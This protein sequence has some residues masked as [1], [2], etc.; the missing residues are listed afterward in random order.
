MD[1]VDESGNYAACRYCGEVWPNEMLRDDKRTPQH[2]FA[3]FRA[4]CAGSGE[5]PVAPTVAQ[6]RAWKESQQS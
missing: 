4:T 5:F 6:V 1:Q 2:N 3:D